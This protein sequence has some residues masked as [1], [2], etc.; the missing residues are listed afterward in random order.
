MNY[1]EMHILFSLEVK[2][3][4]IR[5]L[6]GLGLDSVLGLIM[7][8]LSSLLIA[9]LPNSQSSKYLCIAGFFVAPS[10]PL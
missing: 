5:G 3:L 4:W 8:S 6:H 2:F 1:E 9:H 7:E 10:K